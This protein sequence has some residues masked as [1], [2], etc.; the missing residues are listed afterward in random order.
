[1][2]HSHAKYGSGRQIV[3]SYLRR[4]WL[5]YLAGVTMVASASLLM[6][7][8]PRLLG[9][10]TDRLRQGNITRE[11]LAI[12]AFTL[13]GISVVRVAT[14]WGGRIMV[15]RKGRVL[16]YRLRMELFEKWGTLSPGYYHRHSVG[17]LLSHALSDVE[18]VRELM[19]QGINVSVSGLSLLF[20]TLYLMM[21]HVDWRL[22]L[23]GLGP[24]L[25]IPVLVRWLGP[26]I[27]RQ[28]AK[29]QEALGSMAQTVEEVIGGIRA[30]KAFGTEAVV[31]GR[32]ERTVS[33]IFTEKMT[34]AR[35]SSLFG[36]LVPLMVN[37]G[38]ISVLGFGGY[39]V[40]RHSIT[41]GDFVAFTL[42]V[43]MLR[44]PLEQLG[45]VLN[46]IQRSSA[47]LNRI[48]LLLQVQPEVR[49]REGILID[50]P[51]RG[52]MEVRNLTFCYP[53]ME[54]AVL[55]G[56]SFS[57]KAG[58]TL[59][60][61]GEMGSGKTTLADLLLRL[62]DPPEGTVFLDGRDIF[63]YPLARLREGIAYVPQD[64]FLFSS[65]I[66][67]NIAFSDHYP[68]R[69]RAERCTRI[70]A[71]HATISGFPEGFDT[72]VGDRGVR[73]SG[74][75]KQRIAIARMIYKEAPIQILDDS[76]SAV[77]TWTEKQIVANLRRLQSRTTIIISHR[78][79]AV[80]HADEIIVL[81]DGRIAERGTHRT[82][83][84][85]GGMYAAQWQMQSGEAEDD[86]F[87]QAAPD[88]DIA[89]D[90]FEL[91]VEDAA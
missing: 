24:L 15:H 7:L 31:I 17:E 22:S 65:S 69:E 89:V 26:Q 57:V 25:A 61:I 78:L 59:G 63:S 40:V 50:Q 13:I 66:L 62:Y 80:Q 79:S 64:G 44:Q 67:D 14:G 49:D 45:N 33:A 41:L 85:Q 12:L 84:E 72:E 88:T 29:S 27:K 54:R 51:L 5:V 16:T 38:F 34:F 91:V 73:L 58:H 37:L 56:I 6:A 82:L 48:A 90:P 1:M 68:D 21:V 76:L 70:T 71:I 74:G 28:S 36:A 4:H 8:I 9:R 47:S 35:L 42:Y 86:G 23:A 53:G 19:S 39:L 20:T 55:D 77:D 18:V 87:M 46:I 43:A 52:D 3:T 81:K 83:L 2:A 75:Q 11:E 30:I 32:F 60:I 10:F